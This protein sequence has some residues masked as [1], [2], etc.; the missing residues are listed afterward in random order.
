M[1]L[2]GLE[3]ERSKRGKGGGGGREGESKKGGRDEEEEG[4]RSVSFIYLLIYLSYTSYKTT[5]QTPSWP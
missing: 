3:E 5:G 4:R 1:L 2:C